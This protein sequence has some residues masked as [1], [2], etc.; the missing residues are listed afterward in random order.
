MNIKPNFLRKIKVKK[1]QINKSVVCCNFVWQRQNGRQQKLMHPS[2][3]IDNSKTRESQ[4][5]QLFSFSAF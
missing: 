3:I 2:Y 4:R 5:I 1:N